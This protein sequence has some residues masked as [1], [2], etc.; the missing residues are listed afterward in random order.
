MFSLPLS[1]GTSAAQNGLVIH[2]CLKCGALLYEDASKCSFCDSPLNEIPS[3]NEFAT[4]RATEVEPEWR[5]EVARRMQIYRARRRRYLPDDSQSP[6]PLQGVS[7]EDAEPPYAP[8]HL[9][10]PIGS[11]GRK[12]SPPRAPERVEISIFQ[13]ELDFSAGNND[14]AH[15]QTALV[16]VAS[17]RER[18]QAG[19]LD[20]AFLILSYLAFAA[21]FRSL[22][23][24]MSFTRMDAIVFGA[25][26]LLLYVIYFSIFTFFGGATPGMQLRGLYVVRLDGRMADTRQL[27]WRS[28][29]YLLSAGALTMGFLWALWDDDRFTWHDRMSHTYVTDALPLDLA[30]SAEAREPRQTFAHK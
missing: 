19:L 16:P 18:R 23:G 20:L 29:G 24:R 3:E 12:L 26:F 8:V 14:R 1:P 17:L 30:E 13:P 15:P 5:H 28:F 4:V 6:L 25:T 21:M 2:E 11:S 22:G 7:H 9:S 27:L 10:E